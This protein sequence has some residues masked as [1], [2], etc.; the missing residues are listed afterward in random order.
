MYFNGDSPVTFKS[1]LPG[2]KRAFAVEGV[3]SMVQYPEGTTL[4]TI[5]EE[6][7][8][9]PKPTY[10]VDV[11]DAVQA[12]RMMHVDTY[13]EDRARIQAAIHYT[14]EERDRALDE[15]DRAHAKIL[16]ANELRRHDLNKT[17]QESLRHWETQEEKFQKKQSGAMKVF[18]R[19]FGG[20]VLSTVKDDLSEYRF[21]R[22]WF[23]INTQYTVAGSGQNNTTILK[24]ELNTM[25]YDVNKKSFAALENELDIL[26]DSL[27]QHGEPVPTDDSKL[28]DLCRILRTSPGN[29]FEF[30]LNYVTMTKAT[31]ANA[32]ALLMAKAGS[33]ATTTML[34]KQNG[35]G[36]GGNNGR[37]N[38][39]VEYLARLQA[40]QAKGTKAARNANKVCTHCGKD[41]HNVNECFQLKECLNCGK[42][43]HL[44][45]WCTKRTDDDDGGTE[46]K[47][48]SSSS[49][50]NATA[51]I[52]NRLP[53]IRR[54]TII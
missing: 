32:R 1:L 51:N 9:R 23:K 20:T 21:K 42:I 16:N 29:E 30:E 22:S 48:S 15:L 49:K 52:G 17:H 13:E 43:G 37:K 53:L 38:D 19:V 3:L 31:Y 41:G 8:D 5:E 10:Q 40:S 50:K 12:A 39:D 54:I 25:S 7:F 28:F 45:K 14:L 2:I 33:I 26:Y 36:K 6:V 47:S 46:N 44:A 27:V 4:E 35:K 34:V 11:E 18:T 24:N